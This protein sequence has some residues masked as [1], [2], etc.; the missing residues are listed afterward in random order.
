MRRRCGLWGSRGGVGGIGAGAG[1]GCGAV[2]GLGGVRKAALGR[3]PGCLVN[4]RPSEAG[5]SQPRLGSGEPVHGPRALGGVE[6]RPDARLPRGRGLPQAPTPGCGPS[7][8]AR[9]K[10]RE[11][12]RARGAPGAG[13]SELASASPTLSASKASQVLLLGTDGLF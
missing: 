7:A 12:R 3:G 1:P 10:R 2:A 9:E 5:R 8:G 6:A 13:R 11:A 4:R